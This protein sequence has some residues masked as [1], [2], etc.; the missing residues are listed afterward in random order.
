M[1]WEQRGNRRYYYRKRR[2]GGQ[3]VSE[4]VGAG[5]LA[6]ADAA[7]DALERELRQ[8][9][10]RRLAA[11]QAAGAQVKEVCDLIQTMIYAVLL[12]T[13]HH[14]HKGQWRKKRHDR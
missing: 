8:A 6:A 3:V 10:Q 9:Q 11:I 7:L 12:A 14:T 1:G 5:D 2:Q 4:Y 13:G